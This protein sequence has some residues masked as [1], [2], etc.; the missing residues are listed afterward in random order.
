MLCDRARV[1]ARSD[2]PET[3]T[4]QRPQRGLAEVLY[5]RITAQALGEAGAWKR[6][7]YV[8]S[9]PYR[10]RILYQIAHKEL[11]IHCPRSEPFCTVP[12]GNKAY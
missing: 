5:A 1:L 8:N 3:M 12:Q 10:F 4:K 6:P 2:R 11:V 9:E 7:A